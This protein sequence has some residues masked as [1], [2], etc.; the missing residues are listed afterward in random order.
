MKLS[1]FLWGAFAVVGVLVLYGHWRDTQ[2][3]QRVKA[4]EHERDSLNLAIGISDG[5]TVKMAAEAGRWE[6]MV[7]SLV[8]ASPAPPPEPAPLSPAKAPKGTASDS[9]A[10]WKARADTLEVANRTLIGNI[11]TQSEIIANRD[12]QLQALGRLL[13]LS[14]QSDSTHKAQRDEARSVANRAP[15]G[16]KR[17]LNL[18]GVR[19]CPEIGVGYGATLQGGVVRAGPAV[20]VIQPLSCG[21]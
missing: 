13:A 11:R 8:K 15:V 4:W 12:A 5:E 2:E 21:A 16:Q 19:L 18:L 9:A 10:Y 7:D 20:A 1:P 3:S 14:K 17:G 6:R